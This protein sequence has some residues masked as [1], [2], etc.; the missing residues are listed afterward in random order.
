MPITPKPAFLILLPGRV[1]FW[2]DLFL[3][4]QDVWRGLVLTLTN[5]QGEV[6]HTVEKE[7]FDVL[8][9]T[10][11]VKNGYRGPYLHTRSWN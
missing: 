8:V 5:T 11:L 1:L 10:M 3:I 7:P 4:H 2:D 6:C 9:L